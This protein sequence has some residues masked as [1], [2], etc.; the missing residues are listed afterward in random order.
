MQHRWNPFICS[1][2][3]LF[4]S[5]I[6]ADKDT[7]KTYRTEDVVVTATRSE[8]LVTSVPVATDV[9]SEKKIEA[10]NAKNVGEAL[11]AVGASFIKS[12][13]AV[14][15]LETIS[16]RGSTDAQ[17]LVLI[18]GQRLNDAQ[19]GGVDLSSIPIGAV[20]R[21]EVVKGGHAALYGSDAIGGVVNII[22]KSMARN[23]SLYI[24][25]NELY[26]TYN[27]RIHDVS[28]GQGINNFDYFI[29]YNRTQSDGNYGYTNNAGAKVTLANGDTKLGNIFLKAGYL[30]NDNS[31]LSLFHKY[32]NANNGSPGSIS[33]PNYS[34]RNKYDNNHTSL[35]YDG[36]LIGQFVF[37][38]NAY[39][40]NNEQHY[41]NPESWQGIEENV[42]HTKALGF[43]ASACLDIKKYG[44]LSYG[45][46][47]RQDKL[48][49]SDFVNN[50]SMPFIGDHQRNVNSLYLQNDWKYDFDQMWKLSIV[51][52]IRLDK[53][54]E[55]SI[56][57]QFS[58]KIG[59]N[60]S[61]DE[62][63]I[64]SIRGNVGRV[65][66]APTYNDL[67]WPEN[68]WAKGNSSLRP[69]KGLTYDFGFIA[70]FTSIG[71]W[72]VEAT[73]FAS[74][75]NDLI[76]WAPGVVK[77]MPTNIDKADI[78]GIESKIS[79]HGFD[80]I[81]S[82]QI[83]YTYLDAKDGS[84]DPTTSGKYLIYRPKD[85]FDMNINVNYG[86]SSFNV[87]YN[88]IGKR[89][90]DSQNTIEL[91]SYNLISANIG[92]APNIWGVK[93]N[94]RLEG[95]NLANKEIQVVQGTPLPG[96]EIRLSIG[97]NSSITGLNF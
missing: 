38:L 23:N 43:L 28:V 56:G 17:V 75:L 36:L 35:S 26:G 97:I 13:G 44:L 63:W 66:R 77:W 37:N 70:Q 94:F 8:A 2:L 50:Q 15:S 76:L 32:Y 87:F 19:Q 52:A 39:Y 58:P 31:R 49:S 14:G 27:T 53:Y 11:Q 4:A 41:I 93:V 96:R 25:A 59:F 78:Q 42:Y 54:P 62:E 88:Y 40:I 48:S 16:L 84:D 81:V 92:V 71:N 22:T 33:I 73:Y 68:S 29:S 79:W 67:Y 51:P 18:D 64:G 69:E 45:Y 7:T 90:H 65:Y 20:Q 30:F 12:Y 72:S 89:F 57:S 61:H 3:V 24:N 55:E 60:F 34:A 9:V 47:F 5:A 21:I 91:N 83:S 74:K 82:I 46:E 95:N 10:S 6:A 80:N 1:T 86:I 85:K